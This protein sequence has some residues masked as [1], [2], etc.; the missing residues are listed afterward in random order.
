[1][2]ALSAQ[3][4]SFDYDQRKANVLTEVERELGNAQRLGRSRAGASSRKERSEIL[5]L[6]VVPP[7]NRAD[8]GLTDAE[9]LL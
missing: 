5:E 6:I 3:G 7:F 2:S 4:V 9:G 8:S 1:V